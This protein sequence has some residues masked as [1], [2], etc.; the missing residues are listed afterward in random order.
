MSLYTHCPFPHVSHQLPPQSQESRAGGRAGGSA[1]GPPVGDRPPET[2][3]D[4]PAFEET[5]RCWSTRSPGSCAGS[6]SP[7]GSGGP[8]APT[9]NA[10]RAHGSL[11]SP[12]LL[13]RGHVTNSPGSRDGG[14]VCRANGF[15]F[16]RPPGGRSR[17]GQRNG[18]P[19]LERHCPAWGQ[20]LPVKGG[21]FGG[22]SAAPL[23][24][25]PS[26]NSSICS[27]KVPPSCPQ[28]YF[29][30]RERKDAGFHFHTGRACLGRATPS[31]PHG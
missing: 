12:A 20:G 2:P 7:A 15:D 13:C 28:T 4:P 19:L 29:C 10:G 8:A 1:R 25:S 30:S 22:Q 31:R 18:F 23:P 11:F 26:V 17:E 14:R 6:V 9:L 5:C 16:P 21:I 24:L 27:S 3:L